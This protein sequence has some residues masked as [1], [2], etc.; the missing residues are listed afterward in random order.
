MV[1]S[2]V[3]NKFKSLISR[4]QR[5]MEEHKLKDQ[6]ISDNLSDIAKISISIQEEI[7]GFVNYDDNISFYTIIKAISSNSPSSNILEIGSLSGKSAAL[8]SCFATSQRKLIVVDLFDDEIE[9]ENDFYGNSI[10]RS[11]SK[12]YSNILRSNPSAPRD[13]IILEKS[14]SR[15]FDYSKHAPYLFV[16]IDGG[17]SH[18]TCMLDL[19]NTSKYLVYNGIIAVDD[20]EHPR[21]PGVTTAVKEFLKENNNFEPIM[22]MSRR[23]SLGKKMYMQK[24]K[25]S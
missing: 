20:Y 9:G 25:A 14:D 21:Y 22:S 12:I 5:T 6:F 10:T 8:L 1:A 16:H 4:L 17:H 13:S 24:T 15:I 23:F 11:V 2:K 3:M 7:G 18:E 19:V